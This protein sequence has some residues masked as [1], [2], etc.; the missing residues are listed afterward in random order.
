VVCSA[1]PI[2]MQF[3]HEGTVNCVCIIGSGCAGACTYVCACVHACMFAPFLHLIPLLFVCVPCGRQP[4]HKR[5]CAR[6]LR[7]GCGAHTI[8][9]CWVLAFFKLYGMLSLSCAPCACLSVCHLCLHY[10]QED[11]L[12]LSCARFKACL[13]INHAAES[14]GQCVA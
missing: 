6:R 9:V 2:P 8:S 1:L 14:S 12:L 10:A 5:S 7:P 4:P 11:C 3:V 13:L